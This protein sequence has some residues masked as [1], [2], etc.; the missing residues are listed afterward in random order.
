MRHVC[1]EQNDSNHTVSKKKE[2]QCYSCSL[3]TASGFSSTSIFLS[4]DRRPALR[5][6]LR[7]NLC[8]RRRMGKHRNV[9]K[10]ANFQLKK[11][12]PSTTTTNN[13]T[14][15][16]HTYCYLKRREIRG[17]SESSRRGNIFSHQWDWVMFVWRTFHFSPCGW[18][19]LIASSQPEAFTFA[20]EFM[21]RW[22]QV[23]VQVSEI[24][25]KCFRW[26]RNLLPQQVPGQ[27][28][29]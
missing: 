4:W 7:N 12:P 28:C 15:K 19:S 24:P 10:I 21:I 23:Y 1:K 14:T 27:V 6:T 9:Q 11:Q 22:F 26:R 5:Q 17:K 16:D 2:K 20:G 8:N 13:N 25:H 29:Q 3:S 18:Q